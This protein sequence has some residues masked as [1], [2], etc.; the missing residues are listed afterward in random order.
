MTEGHKHKG[1]RCLKRP[2]THILGFQNRQIWICVTQY[3]LEKNKKIKIKLLSKSQLHDTPLSSCR[4]LL[5]TFICS[6]QI[7]RILPWKQTWEKRHSSRW[8]VNVISFF[9][10]YLQSWS[11]REKDKCLQ[12]CDCGNIIKMFSQSG[13]F[14]DK[15]FNLRGHRVTPS[16]A[17][18]KNSLKRISRK[19]ANCYMIPI[20]HR[21]I[22]PRMITKAT[23]YHPLRDRFMLAVLIAAERFNECLNNE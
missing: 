4:H 22:T 20:L 3:G 19:N 9:K 23:N 12:M 2:H 6:F 11:I 7:C 18:L 8:Q 15:A 10:N 17:V 1:I 13:K 16:R 21:K 14:A 5:S